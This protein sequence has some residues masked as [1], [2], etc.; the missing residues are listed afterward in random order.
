MSVFI[1]RSCACNDQY[2]H[3]QQI[4]IK[5]KNCDKMQRGINSLRDKKKG[6]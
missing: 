1:L 3:Q 2:Q 5:S 6:D 4:Q